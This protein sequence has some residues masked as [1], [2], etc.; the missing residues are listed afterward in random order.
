MPPMEK[1]LDRESNEKE[2]SEYIGVVVTHV[3]ANP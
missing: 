3:N 2:G 1:K